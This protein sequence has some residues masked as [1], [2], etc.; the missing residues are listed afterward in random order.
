MRR[1]SG[2][3]RGLRLCPRLRVPIFTHRWFLDSNNP[4]A[5][6]TLIVRGCHDEACP[7]VSQSPLGTLASDYGNDVS[8]LRGGGD[9][10][11]SSCTRSL[12]PLYGQSLVNRFLEVSTGLLQTARD[13]TPTSSPSQAFSRKGLS[14]RHFRSG[15]VLEARAKV[16]PSGATVG[17]K[18][19]GKRSGDGKGEV[20]DVSKK[21]VSH[22]APAE[23][24]IEIFHGITLGELVARLKQPVDAVQASLAGLGEIVT[25][26]SRSVPIDAAELVALDAGVSV[27]KV[28]SVNGMQTGKVQNAGMFRPPVVTVMGHVDHGKTSLLD[29]LRQTSLAAREAGGITQHLGAFVVAMPSGASLTFLDTPGHAAFSA[30]RARGAAVTDIVVLVV[31]AD[32]GVMPQTREALA[33]AQ[34]AKVPIVVAINKCDK[35]EANPDR[36]RQQL[37]AEGLELEE[38]G[39]DVQV[40]EVSAVKRIG[41]EKL[42]EALLLQAEL[43][44]LRACGSDEP[45]AVV[46]EARVDRGQG[47]LA[48][49]IVRSGTIVPGMNIVMG[50]Q[51]GRIRAL[52]DMLGCQIVSAGPSTP[53]EIDGL[54]GLPEA[55]DE[56]QVVISEER[57]R[58]LSQARY[59]RTE[60]RRHWELKQRNMAATATAVAEDG[61]EEPKLDKVEMAVVVKADVQGTAQAVSQALASLSCPQVGVNIIHAGVG[62]IS[63]SDVD[64]AEACGACVVGFNVRSMAAAVGAAARRAK[65]N[66]RE[67]R[68]IY[69]LLEDVGSLIVGMA[70][71]TK[72]T[73]V[74]GQAEV[75]N[76]FELKGKGREGKGATKI[77]GCRVFDGSLQRASRIRV[78][79]SGEVMFEGVCQSL[80]R[81][82]VDVDMVGKGT[83]CGMIL[84]DWVDFRVGDVVQCIEDVRRMPKYVSSQNGAARIE[85]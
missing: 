30:M 41:L 71:G 62:P 39:G 60:E 22:A 32:D 21:P 68:I 58:K 81:E 74:A 49:V 70:P 55:G 13:I 3:A 33:H 66:I 82:K 28:W 12:L 8:T 75:L 4:R 17:Y 69:H 51:W 18:Y 65:I 9:P 34:A 20:G 6:V 79:R 73:Q 29:A 5:L 27:K 36:V 64:L 19:K 46:V 45:H 11:R 35:A 56:I 38:L 1:T 83:E 16:G 40:V 67:H 25:S 72:E 57:A 76:V 24:V 63:Q 84:Q 43:M 23:K 14:V 77:A 2:M 53:V 31:A 54:R 47:P 37:A 59:S 42:E 61:T 44:E 48:T 85:C 15:G 7:F 26:P 10:S 80:K 50:T 78:L 52:R